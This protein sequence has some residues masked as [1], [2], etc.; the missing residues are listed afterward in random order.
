MA[1]TNWRAV[2]RAKALKYHINPNIFLRQI[3]QESGFNPKAG[4]PAGAQGIAQI[5]P[6]T[7]R[8]WGV[9]P[10][11]PRAA[12]DAA[13]QA[14]Q[15]YLHSYRGDWRLALAAYNAGVGAV[16]QYHGVPP[17]SE[18]QHYVSSILSGQPRYNNPKHWVRGPT[19]AAA[20]ATGGRQPG[21]ADLTALLST[22]Q[23]GLAQRQQTPKQIHAGLLAQPT[24]TPTVGTITPN[25]MSATGVPTNELYSQIQQLRR[26]LLSA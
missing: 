14:M 23:S 22:L 12:L 20:P 24:A 11:N 2:A 18:T 7:A 8:A 4:S 1:S 21:Q 5:M 13:A 3:S 25:V 19:G 26:K 10:W 16:S 17:Y 15:H 6:A 9:N